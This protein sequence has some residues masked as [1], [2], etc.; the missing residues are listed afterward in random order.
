M[1]HIH[2]QKAQ[3]KQKIYERKFKIWPGTSEFEEAAC[4]RSY[5]K[6]GHE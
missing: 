3:A 5:K 4:D 2:L 1:S 6:I